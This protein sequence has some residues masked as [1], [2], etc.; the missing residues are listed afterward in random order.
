MEKMPGLDCCSTT[1]TEVILI[2]CVHCQI[3]VEGEYYN[4]GS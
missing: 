3:V 2:P 1:V 4:P